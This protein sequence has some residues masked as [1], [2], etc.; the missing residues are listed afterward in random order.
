MLADLSAEST[1]YTVL[2]LTSAS[3]NQDTILSTDNADN[4]HPTQS[5]TKLKVS[6]ST[7]VESTN[8]TALQ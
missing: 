6:A 7:F 4:V 2:P 5:T 3:A 8:S 1:K